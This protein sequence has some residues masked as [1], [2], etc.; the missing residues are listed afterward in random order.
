MSNNTLLAGKTLLLVDDRPENLLS[1]EALLEGS[2]ARLQK[3]SSGNEALQYLLRHADTTSC[4]L[5]DVQMP[6]MSGFEA[7]ALLQQLPATARV[8]VLFV[9]AREAGVGQVDAPFAA[10]LTQ[11]VFLHKPFSADGLWAALQKVLAQKA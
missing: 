1:L 10:L 5:M 7:A 4:V 8:P 11:P 6:E 3:A 9:T 2:G